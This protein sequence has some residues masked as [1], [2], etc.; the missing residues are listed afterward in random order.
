MSADG[1]RALLCAEAAARQLSAGAHV[2]DAEEATSVSEDLDITVVEA[3]DIISYSISRMI[4]RSRVY[5]AT[6]S[7]QENPRVNGF[8]GR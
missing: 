2:E 6:G 1:C 5:V 4:V 3:I 7:S 8:L